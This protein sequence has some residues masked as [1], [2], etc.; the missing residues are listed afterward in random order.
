MSFSNQSTGHTNSAELESNSPLNNGV[1][2]SEK[3]SFV[4]NV[5]RLYV[6]LVYHVRNIEGEK[7]KNK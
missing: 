2:D 3:R 1:S 6:A 4:A 5:Q 7:E